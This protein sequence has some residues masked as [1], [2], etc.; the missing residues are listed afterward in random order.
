MSEV[1]KKRVSSLAKQYE[2]TSETL[3]RLCQDAGLEVKSPSSMLDQPSFLMVKPLLVAEKERMERDEL[4]KSGKKIPMKAVL[5]KAPPR[6]VRPVAPPPRPAPPRVET[7][8]TPPAPKP[9]APSVAPPV[10]PPVASAPASLA[11][12]AASPETPKAVA[13]TA[14]V[15]ASTEKVAQ[16][17]P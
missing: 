9:A 2:V 17:A 7:V 3:I 14:P 8:I 5:K 13:P 10:V 1:A 12:A 11:P 16:P 4:V 15:T 6:P